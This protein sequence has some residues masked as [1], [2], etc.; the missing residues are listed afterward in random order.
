MLRHWVPDILQSDATANPA[1][2]LLCFGSG[3]P[4]TQK[5]YPI[6]PNMA[7]IW[8][9]IISLE[10]GPL[11]RY[12]DPLG[13]FGAG[14]PYSQRG[15]HQTRPSARSRSPR[16][17]AVVFSLL[18]NAVKHITE[19]PSSDLSLFSKTIK[20]M[21]PKCFNEQCTECLYMKATQTWQAASEL[22]YARDLT[23]QVC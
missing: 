22:Q 15:L 10:R 14:A 23:C 20:G 8:P 19:G 11:V 12:L 16:G 21:V 1:R 5:P 7:R 13:S 9:Y 2:P 6:Q 3:D 18:F 17:P 4:S